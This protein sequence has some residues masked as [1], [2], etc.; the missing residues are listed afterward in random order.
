MSSKNIKTLPDLIHQAAI[1]TPEKIAFRS[2]R[3]SITYAD[4]DI[5]VNQLAGTLQELGVEKGDRVGICLNRCLDTVLAIY[6]IMR[7]GGVYVPLDP[8]A[9]ATRNQFSIKDCD[10]KILIS[11]RTQR[12]FLPK[13][14]TETTTL[15]TI[16][17]LENDWDIETIRWDTIFN[18]PSNFNLNFSLTENDLAYIMYTSGS[19]GTP[20]GMTH[21]HA[22]GLN[23]ARLTNQLYN[24]QPDDVFGNHAPIHFDISLLGIFAGPLVGATTVI[25]PDAYTALPASLSQLIEKEQITVW[26]SVPLAL[27]QMVQN[28]VLAERNWDAVRYVFFAG[29]PMPPKYLRV[30]MEQFPKAIY[31]NW[32]GPAETNV[33]TYY[34]LPAPPLTDEPLPIGLVVPT[35]DML[36]L[37][38]QG[39]EVASGETGELLIRSN[40]TMEGYWQKPA[41]TKKGFYPAPDGHGHYYRTGDLIRLDEEGILHFLGRRDHQIKVRG[42]RVELGSVEAALVSIPEILEAAAFAVRDEEGINTIEAAVILQAAVVMDEQEITTVLKTKLPHYFIPERIRILDDFPRTGSGKVQRGAIRGMFYKS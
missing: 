38:E 20:K 41:L 12:N 28:G 13:L 24:F 8:K 27:V 21:T 7:A 6:G 15:K 26:Y 14:F 29:E 5:R 19:T 2:G 34:N 4:F 36:I 40:T 16:I 32:Y 37:D 3:E 30:L 18:S 23:F 25:V 10:I 35:M 42:Y 33:C 17:G 1:Q 11:N 22:S 31:G 9:P 39:Q